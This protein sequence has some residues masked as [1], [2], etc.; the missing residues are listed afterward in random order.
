MQKVETQKAPA[1][2]GPYSQA[3]IA[4]DLVFVSGQ[5]PVAAEDGVVP[6]GIEAQTAQALENARS[7]LQ[8]AGTAMSQVVKVTVYIQNMDDFPAMNA[9]Y[10]KYFSDPYPARAA[11]QAAALPKGV[12][13]EIDVIARKDCGE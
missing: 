13:V 4:G 6:E 2:I 1:A 5:L 11:I 9:C 7:I 10:A 3:V 8:A 12:L